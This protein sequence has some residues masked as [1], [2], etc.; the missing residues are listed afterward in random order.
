MIGTPFPV[1]AGPRRFVLATASV[2]LIGW[3][4]IVMPHNV[5]WCWL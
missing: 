2:A 4:L 5:G 1:G 3:V